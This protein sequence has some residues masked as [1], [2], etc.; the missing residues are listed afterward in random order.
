LHNSV[1]I[2]FGLMTHL[3]LLTLLGSFTTV[4]QENVSTERSL[5]ARRRQTPKRNQLAN[6]R[7]HY[8]CV[9]NDNTNDEIN[10]NN[11]FDYRHYD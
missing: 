6:V 8:K 7:C 9:T 2:V 4:G 1:F 3:E 10:N 11:T 5:R